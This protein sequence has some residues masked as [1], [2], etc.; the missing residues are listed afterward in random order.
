MIQTLTLLYLVDTVLQLLH[1]SIYIYIGM[2]ALSGFHPV[3]VGE[4]FPPALLYTNSQVSTLNIVTRVHIGIG[5][6]SL[7]I[8]G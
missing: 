4:G 1:P 2:C 6:A 3:G 8:V 5:S 7:Y